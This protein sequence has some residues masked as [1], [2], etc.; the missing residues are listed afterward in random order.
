MLRNYEFKIYPS[1]KQKAI[2]LRC[3]DLT[4]TLYNAALEQRI[5]AYS[6]FRKKSL[7]YFDQSKELPNIKK[8][9]PEFKEVYAQ[10][11]Q[12]TLQN[13]GDGGEGLGLLGGGVLDVDSLVSSV[14]LLL[15]C[16]DCGGGAATIAAHLEPCGDSSTH[17]DGGDFVASIPETSPVL[18]GSR[19]VLVYGQ[20]KD[21]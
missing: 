9:I 19:N 15:S 5:S 13:L 14:G 2:L 8:Q 3:L 6:K 7:S 11:L 4:R 20:I 18:T 16:L 12:R 17:L 10:V 1:K 21:G